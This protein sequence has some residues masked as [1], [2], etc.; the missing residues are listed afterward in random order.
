MLLTEYDPEKERKLL[1]K[2]LYKEGELDKM[3]SW[4][5]ILMKADSLTLE[6][7][8][9]KF[10]VPEEERETIREAFQK[11]QQGEGR[12]PADQAADWAWS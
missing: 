3:V 1:E 10:E 12:E 6:Q 2:A 5:S 4:L 7:A 11:K 8:M 9:D